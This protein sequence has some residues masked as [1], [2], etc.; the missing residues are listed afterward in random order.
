MTVEPQN[1][2]L[3]ARA[4]EIAQLRAAGQP[5]VPTTIALEKA[6]NPFLRPASET[7]QSTLGLQGATLVDVFA[8][9][10]KRKDHF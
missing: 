6:T 2:A 5:T 3:Q 9:T 7:L 1:E 4:E 8:E 10:R